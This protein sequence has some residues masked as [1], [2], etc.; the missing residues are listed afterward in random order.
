MDDLR[1]DAAG[2]SPQPSTPGKPTVARFTLERLSSAFVRLMGTP[3][4]GARAAAAK[5]QIAVEPD[6]IIENDDSLPVT[7]RMIV[8]GMLFV[9]GKEGR[10]L[11][12]REIASHIRDVEPA[13]VDELVGQLNAG[14]QQD[15]AAYEIVGDSQ[16]YCL[17]L[18]ADLGRIRD[19][20]R[21]RIR[22][23][24]LTPAAME[25]LSVVA[26]RQGVTGDEVNRLRGS[27]S[28]AILAQLVRRQLVRVERPTAPPRAARYHTTERFNQLFR[29]ASPTDLPRSEDL[30]DS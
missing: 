14:Y 18:R 2:A 25:V 30:A 15:D 3:S 16:G 24:K 21:G 13:E 28:H 6:D 1:D 20:V 17:Q 22:A 27:Q 10:P 9:G 8:E 7:P 19:R 29:I 23:A 12:S 5:P 26:Y 11:T 4:P